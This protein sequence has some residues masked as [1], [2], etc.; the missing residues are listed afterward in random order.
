MRGGPPS[1]AL[2]SVSVP[3]PWTIQADDCSVVVRIDNARRVPSRPGPLASVWHGWLA[4]RRRRNE[5]S[6]A[7]LYGIRR[8]P[9][10][11]NLVAV[12]EKRGADASSQRKPA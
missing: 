1:T 5:R 7:R 2:V 11:P 9:L 6:I 8:L 12:L 10:D 4:F 3:S